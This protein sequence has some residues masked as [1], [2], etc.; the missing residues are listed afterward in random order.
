MEGLYILRESSNTENR[1]N[2][3]SKA[4]EDVDSILVGMGAVPVVC[5]FDFTDDRAAF[6]RLKKLIY[7]FA[8]MRSWEKQLNSVPDGSTVVIQ[9]P[10]RAHT[11]LLGR[12]ID[13][14]RKRSVR[15]IAIIHDLDALRNS[16][17]Y[18]K[19]PHGFRLKLEEISALKKFDIVVAHNEKMKAALSGRFGVNRDSIVSLEI[20]DYVI[21][22]EIMD[23]RGK[24]DQPENGV[25]VAGNLDPDKCG[26]LYKLPRVADFELYGSNYKGDYA[27]YVHYNGAFLPH[28]LP[29]SMNGR[30]G[31]IWDGDDIS[32][33]SGIFGEY[34]KINNPHKT[35]LYLACGIPVII[36]K[37]AAIADFV[38]SHECGVAIQSIDEIADVFEKTTDEAYRKIKRNAEEIGRKLR[39]GFYTGKAINESVS[40]IR[41]SHRF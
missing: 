7:H 2:A 29:A 5:E 21:P 32:T 24:N 10:V 36:W 25:I 34:L 11:V 35:S 4:R 41:G 9:F 17:Y 6:G 18:G 30:Y 13:S 31:L 27:D 19:N 22:D 3:G 40:Q 8:T 28:E 39:A 1:Y 20:F 26:Y 16:Y 14:L 38:L 15:T 23:R 33:C 12:V 37:E